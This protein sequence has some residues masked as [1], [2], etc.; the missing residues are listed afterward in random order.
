[1]NAPVTVAVDSIDVNADGVADL[2]VNYSSN[3]EFP[4]GGGAYWTC[5]TTGSVF[6]L[7]STEIVYR[8]P[9]HVLCQ[10]PLNPTD[11][12]KPDAHT[13][14]SAYLHMVFQYL[15]NCYASPGSI[16]F[17]KHIDGHAYC[18]YL[19]VTDTWDKIQVMRSVISNCP[20]QPVA[21]SE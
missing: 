2:K 11:T 8:R 12:V 17:I 18:G 10:S 20:D 7:D 13:T 21:I 1:M 9:C 5:Y 3:V 6:G 14:S 19:V 4:G 16:G 15:C